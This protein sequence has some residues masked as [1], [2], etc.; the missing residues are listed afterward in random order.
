MAEFYVETHPLTGP[1]QE[2]D[3]RMIT[4]KDVFQTT[5]VIQVLTV[6]T[7]M[8][9]SGVLGMIVFVGGRT[10]HYFRQTC[11][12]EID[13]HILAQGAYHIRYI[14]WSTM[15][16]D[17]LLLCIITVDDNAHTRSARS[18]YAIDTFGRSV[19]TDHCL[20]QWGYVV[21]T[22]FEGLE[23]ALRLHF[24]RKMYFNNCSLPLADSFITVL[25]SAWW[26][27][28]TVHTVSVPH[29]RRMHTSNHR[30]EAKANRQLNRSFFPPRERSVVIRYY[31]PTR[32]QEGIAKQ[33]RTGG[34]AESGKLCFDKEPTSCT[35]CNS[36]S[37]YHRIMHRSPCLL[38]NNQLQG[39]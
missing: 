36:V 4:Q 39:R 6:R 2:L 30:Q 12:R 38:L 18:M 25:W 14:A 23:L 33:G 17:C 21:S 13:K 27:P 5:H 32:R 1:F 35:S 9:S 28:E 20:L 26:R 31:P 7:S 19:S 37:K 11:I 15:C 29:V 8:Y 10:V 34:I 24:F 16:L 3:C 22:V